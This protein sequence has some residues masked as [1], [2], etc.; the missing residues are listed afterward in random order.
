MA[1]IKEQSLCGIW[2]GFTEVRQDMVV[3]VCLH[4]WAGYMGVAWEIY[5]K[6]ILYYEDCALGVKW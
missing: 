4:I 3:I 5:C 6:I 2:C 1:D